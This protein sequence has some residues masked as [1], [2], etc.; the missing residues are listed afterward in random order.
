MKIKIHTFFYGNNYG[1][2]LQSFFFKNFLQNEYQA[3]VDFNNYQPKK[4]IYREEI[5]PILRKNMFHSSVA[6]KKFF[7]LRRWKKKYIETKPSNTFKNISKKVDNFSFY[8]SDEIWNFNNPFFG[9]DPY[10]FGKSNYNVKYS[11]ATS[12]GNGASKEI[13]HDLQVELKKYLNDFKN[14]SVR[15]SSSYNF[16]KKNFNIDSQIVLDPI[17][18]IDNDFELLSEKKQIPYLKN[19]CLIYGQYFSKDEIETIIKFSKKNML[20]IL[21][22][23]YYNK[24]ADINFIDATPTDFINSFKYS[25][26]IF[27]SMFHGVLFS[28]KF[29]KTFWFTVDPYRINK[30]DHILK[31]LDISGRIL[32]LKINPD[33]KINYTAINSKIEIQKKSSKKFINDCI[34]DFLNNDK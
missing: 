12:F 29:N 28:I 19:Y 24:W 34:V 27:T 23:G 9:F 2:L 25:D 4:F 16:L 26:Y 31:S 11:Y 33:D 32:N 10:F 13:S 21:S 30:L 6:I 17:F 22:L 8:G 18:L 5:K 7:K 1:A 20:K 3:I 14:I 15:D